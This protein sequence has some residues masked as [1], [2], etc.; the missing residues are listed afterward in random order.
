M[1]VNK[2]DEAK[3]AVRQR[4]A[5]CAMLTTGR[6]VSNRSRG[7]VGGS[8]KASGSFMAFPEAYE[9]DTSEK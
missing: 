6:K 2:L 7:K 9:E 5:R 1:L 4:I 3:N 8:L